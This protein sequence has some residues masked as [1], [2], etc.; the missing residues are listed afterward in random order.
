M[1]FNLLVVTC[2]FLAPF[3]FVVMCAANIE[4]E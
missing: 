4:A 3:L 2:A 1:I